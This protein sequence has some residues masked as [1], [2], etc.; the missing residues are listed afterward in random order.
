MT[1]CKHQVIDKEK[2][3]YY[4]KVYRNCKLEAKKDGY[5]DLHNPKYIAEREERELIHGMEA[6]DRNIR[7][8]ECNMVG[9]YMLLKE[10]ERFKEIINTLREAKELER[11][12]RG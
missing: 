3:T 2:S 11:L 12:S 4:T 7:E 5:C 6:D 8:S 1:T 10:P 9:R